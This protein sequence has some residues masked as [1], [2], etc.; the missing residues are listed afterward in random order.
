MNRPLWGIYAPYIRQFIAFKRGLGF[1]YHTE[2]TIF[3]LFDRFT[4]QR[5]ESVLGITKELADDW[6]RKKRNESDSYRYHRAICLNRLASFLCKMGISSYIPELPPCNTTFTPYVFSRGQ[7]AA[8]FRACDNLRAEKRAMN[9]VIFVLPVLVRLLYGTGLRIGEALSLRNR[10]ID[11]EDGYLIIKDSK[12][13]KERMIPMAGSLSGVCKEYVGYRGMLP[14]RSGKEDPF[15]V[16]LNGKA[17]KNRA[18]H[19]WFR[20]SLR[21]AGIPRHDHGPRLHDLRHTFCVHSL[22]MMAE[23]GIDMYCSLPVLS[24]YIGHQSLEA[25]D[26][27]LRLTQEMFPGLL[28]DIDMICSNVF[29]VPYETD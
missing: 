8:L 23:S 12:N 17:C 14:F 28:K 24:T 11:L 9:S 1:K 2:E 20:I 25:T 16:S 19:K 29:P 4:L 3:S 10:D 6:N 26:R 21:E 18:I 15:F 13:G 5:K 22:A 7:I 27:Y